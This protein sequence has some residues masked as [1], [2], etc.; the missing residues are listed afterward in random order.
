[1]VEAARVAAVHDS[2]L[3]T[4]YE[5]V[6]ERRGDQKAVVA[7]ACKMLKI[8]WF[9]LTKREEYESANR[10]RFVKKLNSLDA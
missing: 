8:V 7:L 4:F 10:K 5:R 6:R 2:R 9:M 1:M 3:R